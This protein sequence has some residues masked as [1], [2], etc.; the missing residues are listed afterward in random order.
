MADL[1]DVQNVLVGQIAATL[2]PNG[3]SQ[4]SAVSAACRVGPGWPTAATLDPDLANGV[5]NIS[6]YPANIERDT[7]RY[8]REWQK[9]GETPPTVTLAVSGNTVTVGGSLPT[10]AIVQNVAVM[11]GSQGGFSYAVQAS[12]TLTS[13]ASALA[14]LIAQQFP[15]TTSNGDVITVNSTLPLTARVGGASTVGMELRRQLRVF[16]VVIWSPTPTLRDAVAG[17]LDPLF[18]DTAFLTMPDGF[19]ARLK[20]HSSSLV[21]M[22]EKANLYRRDLLYSVEYATTKSQQVSDVIVPVSKATDPNT[23]A[24]ISTTYY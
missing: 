7:T 17:L 4:A 14:T 8:L 5:V 19:A 23:S 22:Q 18:A 9:V 13:I 16:R 20:Y 24:V 11:I 3:T 2:Y 1:S 10:P 15:G 6:V 12:D 21:D